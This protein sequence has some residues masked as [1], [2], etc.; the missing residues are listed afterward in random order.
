MK[1][2]HF[3]DDSDVMSYIK[4]CQDLR[5]EIDTL[6]QQLRHVYAYVYTYV[7]VYLYVYAYVYVYFYVYVYA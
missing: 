2:V 7:Y 5:Q 4:F 3:P 1:N 6:V